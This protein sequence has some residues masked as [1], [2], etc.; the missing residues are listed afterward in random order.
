M[1]TLPDS[2]NLT[3]VSEWVCTSQEL[4]GR[5]GGTQ[6]QEWMVLMMFVASLG[7]GWVPN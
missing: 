7:D 4:Q 2:S 3:T 6:V 1:L 5:G